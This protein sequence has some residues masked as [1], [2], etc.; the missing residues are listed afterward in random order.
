MLELS[1]EGEKK[2]WALLVFL[3]LLTHKDDIRNQ[4]IKCESQEQITG[5]EYSSLVSADLISTG[6]V[7][8]ENG[9]VAYRVIH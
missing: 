4:D 1:R 8:R 7:G 9:C 3:L 2:A 5:R 6:R